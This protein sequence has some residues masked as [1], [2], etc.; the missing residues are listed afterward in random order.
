MDFVNIRKHFTVKSTGHALFSKFN[1]KQY[2]PTNLDYAI[3][4]CMQETKC[5]QNFGK[6]QLKKLSFNA[7]EQ[8]DSHTTAHGNPFGDAENGAGK[9]RVI[10]LS[11][12]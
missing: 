6:I 9:E 4:M 11:Q 10:T 5:C 3:D 1:N 8:K 7:D 12:T 2:K